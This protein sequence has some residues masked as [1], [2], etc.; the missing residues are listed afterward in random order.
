MDTSKKPKELPESAVRVQALIERLGLTQ[1]G[2][3]LAAVA[4]GRHLTRNDVNKVCTG[5]NKA[6][7]EKIRG[8]LAA[9]MKL[10]RLALND[11]LDGKISLDDL[12]RRQLRLVEPSSQEDDGRMKF[13]QLR[14]WDIAEREA[15]ETA[16]ATDSGLTQVDFVG[17]RE[18]P[19]FGVPVEVT[20]RFVT[21]VAWL[22]KQVA[23]EEMRKQAAA[24]LPP[25]S[26]PPHVPPKKASGK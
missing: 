2:V 12:L 13:G 22:W 25:S 6:T 9:G 4:A 19:V 20:P 3:A 18:W 17:A 14:G 11:Y 16:V 1:E 15:L 24:H 26:I 23:T 8:G 5:L 10:P 7:T 21:V